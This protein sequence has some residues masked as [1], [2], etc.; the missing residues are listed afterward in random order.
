MD[1]SKLKNFTA[2]PNKFLEADIT[3][4][5]FR[6]GC[7]LMSKPD[8]W[9]FNKSDIK[10][11]FNISLSTVSR[12]FKELQELDVLS[13]EKVRIGG[14]F[15]YEYT[16]RIYEKFG[17]FKKEDEVESTDVQTTE[18]QT[19][20]TH[21]P[22]TINDSYSNTDISKTNKKEI[23]KEKV[24][25]LKPLP[26]DILSKLKPLNLGTMNL[27]PLPKNTKKDVY[28]FEE[29]WNDY[30]YKVGKEVSSKKWKKLTDDEK[31]AIKKHLKKYIPATTDK[32]GNVYYRKH[33]STYLNQKT[34]LDEDIVAYY[35][36]SYFRNYDVK[37]TQASF[38]DDTDRYN[39][40]KVIIADDDSVS[41]TT[42]GEM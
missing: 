42:L 26:T 23:T 36:K 33:P 1:S 13:L 12:S 3:P 35:E 11:K 29:F 16:V 30:D 6:I 8:G 34:W 5:A 40:L 9:K 27:K 31:L 15:A 20:M 25:Q 4:L 21:S 2:V 14:K 37:Q 28:P 10:K 38:T 32:E 19:S 41:E 22:S 7:Y 17:E 24:P 39:N 18:A